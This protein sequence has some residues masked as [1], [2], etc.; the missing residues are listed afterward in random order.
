MDS[1]KFFIHCHTEEN[2]VTK[3]MT[4]HE[5]HTRV[6]DHN[7]FC[8]VINVDGLRLQIQYP[9]KISGINIVLQPSQAFGR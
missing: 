1:A 5:V 7:T 9:V 4:F 6:E 2:F 8:D 3:M